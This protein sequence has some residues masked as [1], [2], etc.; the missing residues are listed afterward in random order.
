MKSFLL[1]ALLLVASCGPAPQPVA[2]TAPP[3]APLAS[4]PAAPKKPAYS[5]DQ[6]GLAA[7]YDTERNPFAKVIIAKLWIATAALEDGE[8][9]ER[10]TLAK[11]ALEQSNAA[12]TSEKDICVPA[13]RA[14]KEWAESEKVKAERRYLAS[15]ELLGEDNVE[16]KVTDKQV[17]VLR[18]E[19]ESLEQRMKSCPKSYFPSQ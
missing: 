6:D 3:A 4:A 17:M 9:S 7:S 8:T 14:T 11:Q 12:L 18:D 10:M 19:I 13:A 2:P 5:R 15:V 16:S 1:P